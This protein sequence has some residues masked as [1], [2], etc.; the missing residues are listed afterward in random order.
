M[1]DQRIQ[2]VSKGRAERMSVGGSLR[3]ASEEMW[4]YREDNEAGMRVSICWEKQGWVWPTLEKCS[5]GF[6]ELPGTEPRSSQEF[7]RLSH[8]WKRGIAGLTDLMGRA[9]WLVQEKQK[10]EQTRINPDVFLGRKL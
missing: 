7:E 2:D 1:G 5:W 3:E 4:V 10:A 6:V 9:S 8:G